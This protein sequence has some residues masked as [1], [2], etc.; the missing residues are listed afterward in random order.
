MS[1]NQSEELTPAQRR[2]VEATL[3]KQRME[4][5]EASVVDQIRTAAFRNLIT[6]HV[7]IDAALRIDR[8]PIVITALKKLIEELE[9]G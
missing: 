1:F 9:H 4:A 2:E 8:K 5:I 3:R 6:E 7:V